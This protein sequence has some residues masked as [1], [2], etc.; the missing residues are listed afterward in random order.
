MIIYV[1]VVV[2]IVAASYFYHRYQKTV[3]ASREQTA[4]TI[5]CRN[6]PSK[7][8]IAQAQAQGMDVSYM[9]LQM[10]D[11]LDNIAGNAKRRR[12]G[13]TGAY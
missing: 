3:V 11:E 8:Q 9:L 1:S 5:L 12:R 6:C 2:V 10:A 4:M 7:R 13:G